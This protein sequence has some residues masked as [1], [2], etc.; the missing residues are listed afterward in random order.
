MS[1]GTAKLNPILIP[2]LGINNGDSDS[3]SPIP[4]GSI[5]MFI[6]ED[7]VLNWIKYQSR[8]ALEMGYN[9]NYVVWMQMKLLVGIK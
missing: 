6:L 9:V 5:W 8:A 7:L 2:G 3:K 4:L 1:N